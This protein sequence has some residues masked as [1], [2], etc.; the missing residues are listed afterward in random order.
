MNAVMTHLSLV[1]PL[2][3]ILD[4]PQSFSLLHRRKN[5]GDYRPTS[6]DLARFNQLLAR[7]GRPQ[8]PLDIDRLATAARQL[9]DTGDADAPG[10]I[11]QRIA[12]IESVVAMAAERRLPVLFHAGRGIPDLGESV[13]EMATAHPDAR[14][15]LAHAGISDLGLLAPRVHALP[16]IL[17]DTS[18]WMI[19]DLLTLFTAVP[20]GQILY[21][22]DMP[23]GGPRYASM[24]L[25]RCARAAG[26]T[27]HDVFNRRCC[28]R[29]AATRGGAV[30]CALGKRGRDLRAMS[31]PAP[32]RDAE[33]PDGLRQDTFRRAH[34]GAAGFATHHDFLS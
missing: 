5:I 16:N 4:A 26:L 33:G 20:P 9:A 23:Y 21:A 28:T 13:V 31:R 27:R 2:P 17:F 19:S 32:G 6:A 10:C 22:S 18:W 15:I 30:L 24:A 3:A 11:A 25:L 14:L 8:P 34:G 29:T 7:L 1:Q 12:W